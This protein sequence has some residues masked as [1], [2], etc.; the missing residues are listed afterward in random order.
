MSATTGLAHSQWPLALLPANPR[1]LLRLPRHVWTYTQHGLTGCCSDL[2]IGLIR[3]LR[4]QEPSLPGRGWGA[5]PLSNRVMDHTRLC[6]TVACWLRIPVPCLSHFVDI[7]TTISPDFSA[8]LVIRKLLPHAFVI[9]RVTNTPRWNSATGNL[10]TR[11][12]QF[13]HK[14]L[15]KCKSGEHETL[16]NFS[17]LCIYSTG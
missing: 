16:P 11:G 2:A 8:T 10:E 7:I 3:T 13:N 15:P 17:L 4:K 9:L 14:L 5:V 12:E 6:F 1:V